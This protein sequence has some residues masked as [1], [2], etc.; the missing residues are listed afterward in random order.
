MNVGTI[1]TPN[2][3]GQIVIPQKMRASLSITADTP[4]HL[5]LVGETIMMQPIRSVITTNNSDTAF[6]ELLKKTAG[7]W[8]DD[9]WPKTEKR[10]RK[11][12]LVAAKKRKAISW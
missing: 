12:E 7:S 9:D 5:S 1:V 6:M 3:K 11:I 2:T 10:R 8:A 4:L